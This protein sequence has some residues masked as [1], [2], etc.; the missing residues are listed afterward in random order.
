M[1]YRRYKRR[2]RR[3]RKDNFDTAANVARK[4]WQ[5]VKAIR[6]VLNP[7]T[8]QYL[9][10]TST[11]LGTTAQNFVNLTAIAQGDGN[12]QREGNSIKVISLKCKGI[13]SWN[14]SD[15][16]EKFDLAR[17]MIIR[18][19]QQVPDSDPTALGFLSPVS[20]IGMYDMDQ[21]GFV[22]TLYDHVYKV[23][24]ESGGAY[25]NF[26][27]PLQQHVLYNGVLNSDIQKNGLY[28]MVV[29]R[30]NTFKSSLNLQCSVEYVDN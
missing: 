30:N 29:S 21:K 8:K 3:K 2:Y 18:T 1:A 7:E 19:N 27:L 13:L 22:T 26:T 9:P 4:A 23:T 11:T 12:N 25:I 20:T 15:T 28:V 10:T 5:G 17:L 14:L 16:V 24:S 6:R